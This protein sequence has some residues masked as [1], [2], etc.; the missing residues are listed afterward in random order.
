MQCITK[1]AS[2]LIIC[3][4]NVKVDQNWI[5]LTWILVQ[6]GEWSKS[7]SYDDQREMA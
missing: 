7:S 5:D 1:N 4:F 2:A 6:A 3:T